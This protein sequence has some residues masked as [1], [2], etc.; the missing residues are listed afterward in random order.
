MRVDPKPL[1]IAYI[2]ALKA[3]KDAERKLESAKNELSRKVKERET[4]DLALRALDRDKQ[5]ENRDVAVKDADK[6]YLLNIMS[7]GVSLKMVEL[8][9]MP[10]PKRYAVSG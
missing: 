5:L 9:E 10:E 1:A 3:E 4:A 7:H 8:A 6:L 2:N